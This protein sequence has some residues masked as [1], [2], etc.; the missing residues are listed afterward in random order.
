VWQA[1]YEELGDRG[2]VV[3]AVALDRNADDVRPWAEQAKATYPVLIDSEHVVADRY[4]IIN[5]PTGLWIDE[6]GRIVRPNDAV[7]GNDAFSHMTGVTSGPHLDALRAWV[8]TGALPFVSDDEV[9]ARQVL[10]TAEEQLARAEFTLAWWLH[11]HNR[12]EAAERHFVRAGELAPH[13]WTI[14]RGSMPIRGL[15]PM[16]EALMPLWNEWVA[17]GLPYYPPM[18]PTR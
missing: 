18:K 2:F 9:R 13:D 10:P 4:R 6:Q 16:G 12:A 3:L 1:L 7:F 8:T 14:R 17:A 11:R 15:D 5:V